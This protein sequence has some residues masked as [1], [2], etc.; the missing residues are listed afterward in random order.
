[1]K[2]NHFQKKPFQIILGLIIAASLGLNIYL[3]KEKSVFRQDE[4]S[5]RV[6]E[7]LDGDSFSILPDQT[8]RLANVDAPE[9]E[10]CYGQEAKEGLGK[11]I[12]GKNVKIEKTG[13]DAFNRL[14]AFVYLN[15][16]LINETAIENGWAKYA[17]GG[18]DNNDLADLLKEKSQ[19]AKKNKIGVWSE[20]CYQLKNPVDPACN[21]KGNLG[22]HEHGEKKTYHYPG[23][24]EY[25]RT[26]VELDIGEQWFCSEEEA[27]KAGFTKSE[28]CFKDYQKT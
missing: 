5:F 28:H 10:F 15:D 23:C 7:V 12:L 1:M 21:I 18:S 24:S 17:S 14:I 6:V 2:L 22:K 8:I 27:R 16:Q 20:K 9:L 26:V 19:E 13:R 4:E 3:V 25:E 11:L